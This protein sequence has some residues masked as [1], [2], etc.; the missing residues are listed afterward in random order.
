[1]CSTSSGSSHPPNDRDG[2]GESAQITALTETVAG[3]TEEDSSVEEQQDQ[4]KEEQE[5]TTTAAFSLSADSLQLHIRR[6]QSG[7][8]S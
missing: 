5:P 3:Y 6:P 1:V 7:F 2:G 4:E 8:W